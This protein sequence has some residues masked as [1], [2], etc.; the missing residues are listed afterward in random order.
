MRATQN[1][2]KKGIKLNRFF[3]KIKGIIIHVVHLQLI[4]FKVNNMQF[5]EL[6]FSTLVLNTGPRS[7]RTLPQISILQIQEMPDV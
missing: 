2:T 3:K 5:D 1:M 4:C 6:L 7:N